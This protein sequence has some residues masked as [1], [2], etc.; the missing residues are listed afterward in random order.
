M[1]Q[2]ERQ[3]LLERQIAALPERQRTALNLCFYEGL[4]NRDAADIMGI[5]LKA[6]QS[7]LMRAKITLK[8]TLQE[9]MEE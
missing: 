9:S 7:L 8:K 2:G 6:L 1:I 3:R 4:S 5:R